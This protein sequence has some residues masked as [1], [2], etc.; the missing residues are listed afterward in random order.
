MLS[1]KEQPRERNKKIM[2]MLD[3]QKLIEKPLLETRC[4]NK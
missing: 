4:N 3:K 2:E 1:E